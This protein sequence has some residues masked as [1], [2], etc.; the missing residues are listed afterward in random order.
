MV[1]FEG[2]KRGGFELENG[3]EDGLNPGSNSLQET[4]ASGSN[5][6]RV[7]AADANGVVVLP[8]GVSL[9]DI[10]VVGRDLVINLA[11]GSQI[12]I[13]DGA[14]IVPQLVID[15]VAVPPLN[16]AALL[17]DAE[18]NPE[19]EPTQVP[20]SG[21][22]F[23]GDVGPIQDA[24]DLGDLLPYTDL[25]RVVEEEEEVLP[26]IVNREPDVVI[27]TPDNPVGVENAIATVAER[28][29]PE[30]GSEPEGTASE[31][32]AETTTGT[33]VF[34]APDG[35]SSIL[36]NGVEISSVGQVF[37]SPFG[38]LTITSIDLA[39]GEIGF[40]YTLA[41]N[42]VGETV[43]GFFEA[44]VIDRDGDTANA[45]LSIIVEDDSPIAADDIGIVPAGTHDPITG[46]VLDNDESGAD[47]YS[48]DGAVSGFSN[49]TGSAD[50][51]ETLQGEYGTLTLN[52][53]GSYTYTRD[54][55]TPGG[56][57][58]SFDY[59][60]VDQDGSTST[61]TLTITIEDAPDTIEIPSIGDGTVVDEAGLPPRGDEPVGSGEGADGDP[62]DNSDPSET[63]GSTITFNSPDGVDSITIN[64]VE[65]N[66]GNDAGND[67]DDQV[68][69]DDATGT[70]VI[71]SVTYDPVTGDG[72]IVYEYTL[73]DNTDGDDTSVSF[74]VVV[75]DLDGD[76]AEDTL[77][78]T[79][80][81]DVPTAA[82]DAAQSVAEDAVG[83]IGANVLANDT[84]G[85][86][87]A[88]VTS[89]TV[90]GVETA[91][92]QD[93]TDASY[94]NANGTYTMD[95][96]GNWT[97]DPN[98]NL[99]QSGGDIDASFDY[100]ITDG[101][102]DESSA[103]QPIS[104]EDGQDPV[105][106]P[107]ISLTVDDENLANGSNPN[108]AALTDG[109]DIVFTAG[110]DDI[111]SI[112]FGD[113]SG[114]GG[115][116]TWVRVDDDT[117][118]G[119]DGSDLI[120]TLQL[121]RT[122]DTATVEAT[123]SDNYDSHPTFTADDLQALGSVDVIATDIDGDTATSSVAVSVSDDVPTARDDADSL[124]EGG[125]TS[126]DGNV[127]TGE[128]TTA[129]LDGAGADTKGAD[130]ATVTT[131]GAFVGTYGTLTLN[132]D[133]SY[134]YVLSQFG[135]DTMNG[136][137]D[138]ESVSESFDYTLTDGDLDSSDATLTI[139]INGEN[140]IVTINDLDGEAPELLVDEDDLSPDGS[141]QSD[142]T[143]DGDSFTF[144]SP[145]GLEDVTVGGEDVIVDGVFVG[146]VVV[147]GTYGTLTITGFTPNVDSAGNITS[148]SFDYEY[149]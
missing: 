31:T 8:E 90:G 56:V 48:L 112:V 105:A 143:T 61:A 1:D 97:F 35:L 130:D 62:D 73:G 133:G 106:G 128:G 5:G 49:A 53:D 44:T 142:S 66:L 104:I 18:I 74:D 20:S 134:N 69:I 109:D 139:T 37:S 135:I 145:D 65:V 76:V 102:G 64:G 110:S 15:G 9:D 12:I 7:L 38:D 57:E 34:N 46:N 123:L 131:T 101:D 115:G 28:G 85:A 138:G 17:N 45:S 82:D 87:G 4:T 113:V 86:D 13:P 149:T 40:S 132:A 129:G 23:A 68:I 19:A 25:A 81:D 33:I 16:L 117:I 70:L 24:F 39:N 78:I 71:T 21:G 147:V 6:T 144:D 54:V 92:P 58:E 119:S 27:E 52:A 127:I 107:P 120:V 121:T 26:D 42:L 98:P 41:D 89:F 108:P 29:L 88:T 140:D 59:T 126:T 137:S 22:N 47:D 116:L 114:L 122:G 30:R 94:S 36:I 43:D 103:T 75:T 83:T 11:D 118:T 80:I 79:I 111:A 100:T 2:G 99:D 148:G 32:D 125:P 50:A 63:T 146:P 67:A 51:G 3:V 95:M 124:S 14:I 72:T 93:G 84:Q 60:I 55:N 91:V 136:L 77:T 141:D 10:T 96:D